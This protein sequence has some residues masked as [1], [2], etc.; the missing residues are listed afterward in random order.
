LPK[1][2]S[3]NFIS[4]Q[5]M[6]EI[7]AIEVSNLSKDF[8]SGFRRTSMIK[9]LV[10]HVGSKTHGQHVIHALKNISFSVRRRESFAILG[11]N[12]SGKTTLLK[13]I[14]GI[15]KPTQ[16]K[17]NINGDI[18]AFMQLGLGFEDELTALENIYLYAAFLG[19][20]GR[21]II[22]RLD[23]IVAFSEL[24]DYLNM[25]LKYFSTGMRAR[26]AFSVI[27]QAHADIILLDEFLAVGDIYFQKKCL[28]ALRGLQ[29][30]GKAIIVVSQS[31]DNIKTLCQRALL[32]DKGQQIIEGDINSVIER[33]ENLHKTNNPSDG[34]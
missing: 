17:I 8:R 19:M 30:K 9:S 15:L 5:K 24:A 27:L 13:L 28:E 10:E 11:P 4:I 16:G 29:K 25:K 22:K 32:I 18:I 33:Y 7:N 12:A 26:L 14:A 3:Y 34:G 6:S 31:L 1:S 20:T 21:E 2:F 23:H